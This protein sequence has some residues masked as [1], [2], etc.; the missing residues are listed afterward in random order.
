MSSFI[1]I[2]QEL[3][4]PNVDTPL[5]DSDT[6]EPPAAQA[7]ASPSTSPSRTISSGSPPATTIPSPGFAPLTPEDRLNQ[8]QHTLTLIT[9]ER[10]SLSTSLKSARRDAQKADAA[11]RSEIEL[12]KRASERHIGAEHR[13][14]QKLL[15]LQEATKRAVTTTKDMETMVREMDLAM[16]G[17]KEQRA[18]KEGMYKRIKEKADQVRKEKEEEEE[19][20]R[21]KIEGMRGEMAGLGNKMDRLNGRREKLEGSVIPELLEQLRAIELEIEQ[22]EADP[23]AGASGANDE[24]EGAGEDSTQRHRNQNPNGN[25]KP[26][27]GPIQRPIPHWS[28]PPRHNQSHTRSSSSRITHTPILLTNPHR[29]SSLK[30]TSSSSSSSPAPIA[31]AAST[32]T[33]SSRAPPFE[34]SRP[35]PLRAGTAPTAISSAIPVQRGAGRGAGNQKWMGGQITGA[36]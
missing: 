31:P 11:L 29:Q 28:T 6:A 19:K 16:P 3:E 27:Q 33:L 2:G 34:P 10:D 23:H 17:L 5:E 4:L 20:E 25:G 22:I 21:K 9:A 30:S 13:A 8:L 15:A 32:S 36:G 14:R 7:Q 18:A 26:S 12:L 24:M 1:N 35:L